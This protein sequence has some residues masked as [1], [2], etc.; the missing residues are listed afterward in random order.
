MNLTVETRIKISQYLSY[1]LILLNVIL[2]AVIA[3]G[4]YL[5]AFEDNPPIVIEALTFTDTAYVP[6]DTAVLPFS[7]CK[8][9]DAPGTM[10]MSWVSD[11]GDVLMRPAVDLAYAPPSCRERNLQIEIPELAPGQWALHLTFVYQVNFMA[12]RVVDV[13]AIPIT[14]VA[15]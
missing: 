5:W 1:F 11:S 10:R 7:F 8:H 15:R 9:T 14:V 13:E 12:E 3:Y 2:L 4:T 6:G